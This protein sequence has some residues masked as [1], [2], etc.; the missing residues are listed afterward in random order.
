L[1]EIDFIR[2]SIFQGGMESLPVAKQKI[3]WQSVTGV[4]DHRVVM[5][6]NLFIFDEER[7]NRG[8]G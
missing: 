3:P 4:P 2:S 6:I 8:L 5:R 7:F 1:L